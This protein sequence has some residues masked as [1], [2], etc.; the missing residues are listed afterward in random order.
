MTLAGNV[1][2]TS[3]GSKI[4][5]LKATEDALSRVSPGFKVVAS[6]SDANSPAC[7]LAQEFILEKVTTE[8]HAGKLLQDLVEKGVRA[9]LPTRDG[10]LL[11]WA[12]RKREFASFGIQVLVS[13]EAPL[14]RVLNKLSFY[15][16]GVQLGFPMIPTSANL[17]EIDSPRV[18]V[19]E[20]VGS[21]SKG[22]LLDTS[23][24]V[25]RSGQTGIQDPIFQPFIEGKEFSVDCFL[26]R[27]SEVH[28]L[29]LRWR[30]RVRNGESEVSTTFRD[31]EIEET[32]GRIF[33][34]SGLVG[35][36]V[37]QAIAGPRGLSVIELNPRFG[38]ASTTSLA[39]GLDSL[40][41]AL[42]EAFR[43]GDPLPNFKRSLTEHRNIRFSADFHFPWS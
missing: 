39:V 20:R 9:V 11:A 25:A 2:L 10:E 15:E 19:K 21:G 31:S 37:L 27:T 5:L 33:E 22:V 17:D 18:V 1:L 16:W 29:V 8:N 4:P 28:G 41:W 30:N 24:E 32:V 43:P 40:A 3:A 12:G 35:P 14:D 42:A 36:V 23:R 13:D 7:V 26:T 34:R 6:D 38:G